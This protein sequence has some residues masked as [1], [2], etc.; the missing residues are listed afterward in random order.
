[1]NVALEIRD[2]TYEYADGHRVLNKVSLKLHK[3]ETLV[4]FGPNGSGKTT[5][6]LHMNGILIGQGFIQVGNLEMSKQNLA[7]IRRKVGIVFQDAD[8]QLFMPTVLEDVIFGL[9][10]LGWTESEARNYAQE[11]LHQVGVEADLFQ[12]APYHLSAG[13]KRRVALA[14]VPAINPELLLLDEPTTSLDPPGQRNL[15]QLLQSLKQPMII[16]THDINFARALSQRAI[17]L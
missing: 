15:L 9:L 3:A 8:E 4:I 17:F 1:M 13:E 14:G 7:V 5:L 11:I 6:L 16:A 12:R 2:L 10:N